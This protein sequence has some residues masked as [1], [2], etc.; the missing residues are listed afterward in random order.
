MKHHDDAGVSAKAE[1]HLYEKSG[2]PN[3]AVNS[4]EMAVVR[5]IVVPY[6]KRISLCFA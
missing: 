6:I 5:Q 2:H 3:D 1:W 4:Q